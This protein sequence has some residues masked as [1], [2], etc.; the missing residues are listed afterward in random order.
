[1]ARTG[2]ER[3][4]DHHARLGPRVGRLLVGHAHGD[5]AV[6]LERLVNVTE[7]VGLIPDVR[8]RRREAE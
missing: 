6:A 7:R 4:A 3:F 2:R 1:M 5:D 8:A